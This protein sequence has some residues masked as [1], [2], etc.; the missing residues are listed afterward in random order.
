MLAEVSAEDFD[1]TFE[2]IVHGTSSDALKKMLIEAVRAV[3]NY[4]LPVHDKVAEAAI[5]DEINFVL[6]ELVARGTL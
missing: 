2:E 3:R 5:H 1:E 4:A 6:D